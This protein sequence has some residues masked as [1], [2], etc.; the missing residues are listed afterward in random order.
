MS[1]KDIKSHHYV[2]AYDKKDDL[3]IDEVQALNVKLAKELFKGHS[4]LIASHPGNHS[5]IVFNSVREEACPIEEWMPNKDGRY[6]KFLYEAGYKHWVSDEHIE[7]LKAKVMEFCLSKGLTQMDLLAKNG[8]RKTDKEFYAEQNAKKKGTVTQ[9]QFIKDVLKKAMFESKS[10]EEFL[11]YIENQGVFISHRSAGSNIMTYCVE[12][13][14]KWIREGSLG[15]YYSF[16]SILE[17]IRKNQERLERYQNF[18]I[19]RKN[20]ESF[21]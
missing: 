16:D 19:E 17:R 18:L 5:H 1:E 11:F 8:D 7:Y 21:L 2:I 9:K 4:F 15:E 3:T 6:L 14:K 20:Q 13:S 12:G 10:V